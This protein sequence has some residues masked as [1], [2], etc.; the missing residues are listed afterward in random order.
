MLLDSVVE[1]WIVRSPCCFNFFLLYPYQYISR[2]RDTYVRILCTTFSFSSL[3]NSKRKKLLQVNL[4]K[5]FSIV[6]GQCTYDL[7]KK[8]E[9]NKDWET[10]FS[11]QNVL[12]LLEII[13]MTTYKF[14]DEK[15][16]PLSIHNAKSVFYQFRQRSLSLSAYR[17]K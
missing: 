14:D 4:E 13:K 6:L 1:I 8:L 10:I 5:A 2:I 11:T 12:D 17:E 9:A 16:L 15:Y 7:Q 3:A